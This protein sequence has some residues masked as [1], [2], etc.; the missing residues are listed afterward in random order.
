MDSTVVA[1]PLPY[2]RSTAKPMLKKSI[3][4]SDTTST[5]AGEKLNGHQHSAR[6]RLAV[7]QVSSNQVIR[8]G[9]V[10][11]VKIKIFRLT[12]L[13]VVLPAGADTAE[14]VPWRSWVA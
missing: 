10:N 12:L 2:G 5:L 14:D 1:C 8:A 9:L 13:S 11:R 4:C 3:P 6:V 7:M